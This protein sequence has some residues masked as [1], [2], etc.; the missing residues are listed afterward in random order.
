M[1]VAGEIEV[2]N[3]EELRP[4]AK[5]YSYA[6]TDGR[7]LYLTP[8][9]NGAFFG[10]VARFDTQKSFHDPA[11][12]SFIDLRLLD[13]LAVGFIG[14]ECDGRFIYLIPHCHQDFHGRVAR[15]DTMRSFTEESA[16]SFFD[17][18]MVH[19]GSRGF[20]GGAITETHLYMSPYRVAP[21][22]FSGLITRF[23]FSQD[24]ENKASW[25]VFDASQIDD[26]LRGFHGAVHHNRQVYF[27]PYT[28][29]EKMF[30]GQLL[31]L[32]DAN[33]FD[34]ESGWDSLDLTGLHPRARGFVGGV[35]TE[36]GL[37]LVPYFDGHDRSGLVTLGEGSPEHPLTN[38]KWKFIDIEKLHPRGR[39]F[40][41]AVVVGPY[42]CLVPHCLDGI[43]YHGCLAIWDMNKDISSEDGWFFR[44]I[45]ETDRQ[46]TG[47]MGGC[48]IDDWIYLAPFE[49]AP[50][51]R[52]G[53]V[54][55]VLIR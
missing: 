42:V 55:R 35:S 9:H 8:L 54:A 6:V 49:N 38:W 52:H 37:V 12:W 15:Y 34:K 1:S 39:G 21:D 40:F 41:G 3:L 25:E 32:N 30:H 47:F 29:E 31:R 4:G 5:G 14:A 20:V 50:G 11:A 19:P 17:T 43:E 18:C 16:W 36:Q 23:S 28:R 27:V 2:M 10:E 45:S 26:G 53:R 13:S 48:V 7:F 46:A 51:N 24:F 44:E 33:C 22:Q